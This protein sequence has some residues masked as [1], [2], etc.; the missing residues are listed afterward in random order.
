MNVPKYCYHSKIF[1]PLLDNYSIITVNYCYNNISLPPFMLIT[2]TLPVF[3]LLVTVAGQTLI[4][5]EYSNGVINL[6][7]STFSMQQI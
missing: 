6:L 2:F 7:T 5:F 4:N 1:L 3:I